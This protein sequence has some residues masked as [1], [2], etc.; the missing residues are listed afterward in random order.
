MSWGIQTFN[1][2]GSVQVDSRFE[3]LVEL[4]RGEI[5][6]T[7]KPPS[8]PI[9]QG[10]LPVQ[11][12]NNPK[13]ILLIKPLGKFYLPGIYSEGGFDQYPLYKTGTLAVRTNQTS[14]NLKWVIGVPES[15]QNREDDEDY[16]ILVWDAEGRRVFNSAHYTIIPVRTVIFH[17]NIAYHQQS[18]PT[19]DV[20]L[21]PLP[22]NWEYYVNY[23]SS[24]PVYA[25]G[26]SPSYGYGSHTSLEFI[27]DNHIRI[28]QT[29]SEGYRVGYRDEGIMRGPRT[30]I[31]YKVR[32]LN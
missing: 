12:T 1:P 19:I 32:T 15:E 27:T 2:T 9:F 11:I 24:G 16:G 25:E 3:G 18:M 28:T 20:M 6:V 5:P 29:K 30:L 4:T 7:N 23:H 26:G 31:V 8:V 14:G 21:P 17:P 10:N 22:E 13:W